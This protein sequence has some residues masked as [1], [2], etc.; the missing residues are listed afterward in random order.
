MVRGFGLVVGQDLWSVRN[1]S[2]AFPR[3]R[4]AG[5]MSYV[6]L[7]DVSAGLDDA[8]DYGTGIEW[9]RGLVSGYDTSTALQLGLYVKGALA[10]VNDGKLDAQIKRLADFADE[11]APRLVLLR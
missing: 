4:L 11:L 2:A 1:Y 3:S 5:V 8:T 6:A 9:A 10:N 7:N